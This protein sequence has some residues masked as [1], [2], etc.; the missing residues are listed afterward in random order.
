[1]QIDNPHYQVV[2]EAFSRKALIYDSFGED[3]PNLTRMRLHVY[4]HISSLVPMGST[5]LEL[6]AGTG[7]DAAQMVGRGYRIHATDL[8]PGMVAQIEHKITRYNLSDRLSVQQCSFTDL[9]QVQGGPFDAI[10][11][12]FGGLNCIDDLLLVTR[13]LPALLRPGGVVTW[14]IMPPVC[15][16]E[17]ARLPQDVRVATR[18]LKRRTQSHVEGVT[19]TTTYFTPREVRRALG[20]DFRP[21]RLEGLSVFAPPADNNT[22]AKHHPRLYG[23]L[24]RLDQVLAPRWP[25]RAWGDFFILSARYVP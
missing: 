9:N 14:V 18:R 24:V 19:F 8:A 22:L 11:S 15:L 4:D 2:A 10:Y 6:N 23:W 7:F 13:H 20:P 1:M 12:N 17:L 3:H 25:F 16:W 21:L 5:L